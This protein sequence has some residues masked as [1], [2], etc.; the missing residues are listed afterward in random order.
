[1]SGVASNALSGLVVAT[2]LE[3]E[4]KSVADK[5]WCCLKSWE[6]MSLTRDEVRKTIDSLA[7]FALS[8]AR[9]EFVDAFEAH[10]S[11]AAI[12]IGK[13]V[14]KKICELHESLD[15][16]VKFHCEWA[17]E[18]VCPKGVLMETSNAYKALLMHFASVRCA[19]VS[20][21]EKFQLGP[22][23]EARACLQSLASHMSELHNGC[24]LL[25]V[26]SCESF[27][28]LLS[29]AFGFMGMGLTLRADA[30]L[31]GPDPS[32][33]QVFAWNGSYKELVKIR[34]EA[35]W[36]F[37]SDAC[38]EQSPTSGG[39]VDMGITT[40][41][42]PTGEI[43]AVFISFR[44]VK[45][46]SLKT[47]VQLNGDNVA[48]NK[49]L[50][51]QRNAL[52]QGFLLV[53][54]HFP[55]Y[56]GE[57]YSLLLSGCGLAGDSFYNVDSWLW[58]TPMSKSH[59]EFLRFG[60]THLVFSGPKFDNSESH[61]AYNI[62]SPGD[63]YLRTSL[64]LITLL[65]H[66]ITAAAQMIIARASDANQSESG[67]VNQQFMEACK[68]FRAKAKSVLDVLDYMGVFQRFEGG[69]KLEGADPVVKFLLPYLTIVP[70][71]KDFAQAYDRTCPAF[72]SGSPRR[73]AVGCTAN[74]EKAYDQVWPSWMYGP[75][76]LDVANL[77]HRIMSNPG[78]SSPIGAIKS[79]KD[80]L[81][82]MEKAVE[83]LRVGLADP[84]KSC[85]HAAAS[86]DCYQVA[87]MAVSN[88]HSPS[89]RRRNE[90]QTGRHS[91]IGRQ[92]I[93]QCADIRLMA[94]RRGRW[95]RESAAPTLLASGD[96]HCGR[97]R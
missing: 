82:R 4:F 44:F 43:R 53:N 8:H 12:V 16:M 97:P 10:F 90:T 77:R 57:K 80:V 7:A 11:G 6:A 17:L 76:G 5:L 22:Q 87:C 26:R 39:W 73:A 35:P 79:S 34:T 15:S 41:Q 62:W 59:V 9:A 28:A 58:C 84:I 42:Y 88:Y 68:E 95:C 60:F 71:I 14:P 92:H 21:F 40:E 18:F 83:L 89:A 70:V 86:A 56:V 64:T 31:G 37:F 27:Q 36:L 13:V 75:D 66:T 51:P 46:V 69:A 55:C 61:K 74:C 67:F 29:A 65:G 91:G 72:L 93:V 1:M 25:T 38:Q 54:V 32:A 52:T 49:A 48:V 94:S 33:E 20:A 47:W 50:G 24:K 45:D 85:K 19:F 78:R 96:S 63:Q 2:P 81:S 3:D 30:I 23:S